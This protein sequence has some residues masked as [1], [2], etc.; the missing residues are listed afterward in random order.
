MYQTG[1]MHRVVWVCAT[2][3]I[4]VTLLSSQLY[5][6]GPSNSTRGPEQLGFFG[7]AYGFLGLLQIGKKLGIGVTEGRSILVIMVAD[8]MPGGLDLGNQFRVEQG[9]FANQ[10]ESGLRVITLEHI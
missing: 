4:L 3:S 2:Q 5:L 10:E 6:P 7:E 8:L 9:S 1:G